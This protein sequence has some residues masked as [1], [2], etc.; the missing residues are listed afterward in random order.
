M[1]KFIIRRLL[2]A[3]IT[4][5]MISFVVFLV[6]QLPPGDFV[7][8]MVTNMVAEGE[9]VSEAEILELKESYGLDRLRLFSILI[10]LQEF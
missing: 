2:L 8:I 7:D 3:A 6:I 9:Q 5:L 1:I 10:G 4:L